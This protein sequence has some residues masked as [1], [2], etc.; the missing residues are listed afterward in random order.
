MKVVGFD[1]NPKA[2]NITPLLTSFHVDKIS[3]GRKLPM[4]LLERIANP[5]QVT[6]IIH[7]TS[8]AVLRDST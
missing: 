2:K 4:L 5:T 7:I 8:K 3:L 6:Q 1:N